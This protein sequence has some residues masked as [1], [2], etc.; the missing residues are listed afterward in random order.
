M[1]RV[2]IPSLTGLRFFAALA[3]V[4]THAIPKIVVYDEPPTIVHLLS[5]MSAAGM[6]LFFVLSGFIIFLNYSNAVGNRT[7]LWNFFVARFAR[8][9]PL[10]FLCILLDFARLFSYGQLFDRLAPI[11]FYATMTQSWVY[12]IIGDHS[13]MFQYGLLPQVSWSISTEWMFYFAFPFICAT[14]W[15]LKSTRV[16]LMAAVA[17]TVFVLGLI[18]FLN[19]QAN[20]IQ[21]FGV[22][23]FGP[24][25]GTPVDSFHFWLV[26]YSPYVRIFEFVLGCLCASIYVK[27]AP[28]TGREERF[29]IYLTAISVAA[30]IGLHFLFFGLQP[31]HPYLR[32]LQQLRANFGFA[33]AMALL[34]FVC[35]RYRNEFVRFL[36]GKWIVMG[37][38]ISYSIYLLHFVIIGAFRYEASK[39]TSWEIAVG[40]YVQLAIALAAILGLSALSWRFVEVPCRHFLRSILS[41]EPKVLSTQVAESGLR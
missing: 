21:A 39:M 13:L 34:V 23:T 9:Y 38:Q 25:A 8:L 19:F 30:V 29:G 26:Y 16:K 18:T 11:P 4:I 12:K 3:V 24:V 36:S 5:Q 32:I 10:F 31:A 35:A 6:T 33:P 7:D 20:T 40:S 17:F 1:T 28:P 37:G 27:L 15:L 22:R 14:I 2:E 41:L